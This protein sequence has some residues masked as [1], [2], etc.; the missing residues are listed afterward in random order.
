MANRTHESR[1]QFCKWATGN[2][3][4]TT[5]GQTQDQIVVSNDV[6][7][8]DS[9][10]KITLQEVQTGDLADVLEETKHEDWHDMPTLRCIAGTA[11]MRALV[12]R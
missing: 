7:K 2:T 8:L 5:T 3:T 12:S 1:L 6:W 9:D 11:L 4:C 10:G